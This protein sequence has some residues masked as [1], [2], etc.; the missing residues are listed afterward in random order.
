[1]QSSTS[2]PSTSASSTIPS[3]LMYSSRPNEESTAP[4]LTDLPV[5]RRGHHHA[6]DS[7]NIDEPECVC[8]A[9]FSD[10]FASKYSEQQTGIKLHLCVCHL[11]GALSSCGWSSLSPDGSSRCIRRSLALVNRGKRA[12]ARLP[13]CSFVTPSRNLRT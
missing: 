8:R 1:M 3:P 2:Q 12:P 6:T 9:T 11:Q 13:L 7:D 5:S 4:Q 10:D